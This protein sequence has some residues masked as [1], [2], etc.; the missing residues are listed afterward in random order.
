MKPLVLGLLCL[1]STVLIACPPSVAAADEE[2]GLVVGRIYHVEGDLLRYV[3][4]EKDW[5]ATVPD[6]PF[7]TGDALFSGS[8]GMAELII[9]NGVWVRTGNNTQIQFIALDDDLAE[10]DVASGIVRIQAKGEAAVKV[11][12]PFGYV[13]ADPGTI[14][15]L[16]VGENS[17]EVVSVKGTESF[18][19]SASGGRYDVAAGPASILAD[20]EQVST[21]DGTVDPDWNRWNMERENYW[22]ARAEVKGPSAEYLPP[23]LQND[24]Y[25]LEE[26]GSW[27]TVY[28]EGEPRRCWRPTRVA[29][30][31]SPFTVGHWTDWYGDQT[32]IPGEPFGYVTHHYG[33]W[34]FAGRYW[35]WCPPVVGVRV[36]L[37]LLNIGFSWCPGR[38]AWI[39]SGIH[40]GWVPLAPRETYYCR[41]RWGGR[42]TVVVN[43]VSINQFHDDIRRHAY[44]DHAVIVNRDN[45]YGRKTYRNVRVTNVNRTTIINNYRMAPVVGDNVIRNYSKDR[46]RFNFTN[47]PVREKPHSTV[48]N[49]IQENQRVVR[50]GR[51]EKASELREHLKTIPEGRIGGPARVEQPRGRSQIVPA[52]AV[53]RPKE[54][55][56][57]PEREVKGGTRRPPSVEPG[58]AP[59]PTGREVPGTIV[60]AQPS[61]PGQ[62][63]RPGERVAPASPAPPGRE[64]P[65]T[66]RVMPA[67]PGQP[68]QSGERVAPP[69]RRERPEQGKP[70]AGRVAP[71]Q[72]AQPGQP[73]QP[74]ER[75]APARPERGTP[76]TVAPTQPAR[77]RQPAPSG[78]RGTPGAGRVTPAQPAQP[79]QPSTPATP[80]PAW[81]TP[82]TGGVAPAKPAQPGQ[83]TRPA[84][85]AIPERATPPE[86]A[87]PG[88]GRVTP[89]RPTGPQ[90]PQPS[91]P[92]ERVI[93]AQPTPPAPKGERAAPARPMTQPQPQ[94]AMPSERVIPARPAPAAPQ[95][96]PVRPS[97]PT[98]P[99]MPSERAIPARP[100]M[101]A[102][103]APQVAP[104][105]PEPARPVQ[106][107]APAERVAPSRPAMP[108]PAAPRVERAPARPAPSEPVK[109]EQKGA[110][111]ETKERPGR[112]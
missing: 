110:Q 58:R 99:A 34:I 32:W 37:P 53:N 3:P 75:V 28:Y 12:T 42:H 44:V 97:Q 1:L 14:F 20:A 9:P 33:N 46:Q 107:A 74:G 40:V 112:P 101:P 83:P 111:P 8:S 61:R 88:S 76:E 25:V 109:P 2:P 56:K 64:A 4:E 102:P 5:V 38:V 43:K 84:E 48:V 16:Y 63:P 31:W 6:A 81:G 62:Q 86:P 54:E 60:P 67:R 72:P 89:A 29:V 100:M 78:E 92:A 70:D 105:R 98:Q 57:L 22:L 68:P 49:R 36:G 90:Q 18:V 23:Q 95:V 52:N 13:Q 91:T 66:G 94:P 17:V 35:Y 50:E 30:G 26:N 47:A 7:G 82:G 45:F 103:A 51:V 85:R 19:H 71:V 10:I 77:P 93:P 59:A 11:T 79:A 65:G 24:A 96:A 106:P 15:D 55:L 41:H 39:H 108:E 21:G 87:A 27:D 104:V 80:P 69:S 73:V